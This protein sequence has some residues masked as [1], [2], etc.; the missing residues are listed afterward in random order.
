MHGVE[1]IITM[2]KVLEAYLNTKFL[3]EKDRS[4]IMKEGLNDTSEQSVVSGN[5]QVM[6][7]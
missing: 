7:S 4:K 3:D 2:E 1:G 6:M 5:E